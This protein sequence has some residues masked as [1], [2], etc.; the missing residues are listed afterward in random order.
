MSQHMS[1]DMSHQSALYQAWWN[2]QVVY[3]SDTN[4]YFSTHDATY[5]WFGQGSWHETDT[6]PAHLIPD[7]THEQ[8]VRRSHVLKASKNAVHV[9]A[10]SPF[11]VTP[12]TEVQT[13]SFMEDPVT[14]VDEDDTEYWH[15]Y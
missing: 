3:H 7:G 2:Q 8:V 5:Y 1:R 4:V 13:A 14:A 9:Q 6:L 11:F 10:F 15:E 12:A